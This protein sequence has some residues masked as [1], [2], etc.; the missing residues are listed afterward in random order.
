[1][2]KVYNL[3]KRFKKAKN[4]AVD[5]ISFVVDNGEVYGIIG[6]NGAGKSTTIKCITG[7]LPFDKGKITI[8]TYDII[9]NPNKAKSVI[10][11]VPD[12]HTVYENLTGRE[13]INFMADIYK[14]KDDKTELEAIETE[15]EWKIV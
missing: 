15:R 9:K 4:P 2:L 10:G 14:V 5:D 8:N 7:I 1:M 3:V 6:K 12:N 13:Y 11:Y